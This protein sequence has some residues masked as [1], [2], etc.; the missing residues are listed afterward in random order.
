MNDYMKITLPEQGIIKKQKIDLQDGVTIL[1]GL[2]NCGKTSALRLLDQSLDRQSM[3]MIF[4]QDSVQ[5]ACRLSL[6]IP[7]NRVVVSTR[8]TEIKAFEDIESIIAYKRGSYAEYDFHLKGIR[9]YLLKSPLIREF[10]QNAVDRIFHIR[11]SGFD[12]RYSDGIENII[13]IYVN[14]LWILTWDMELETIGEKE[15]QGRIKSAPAYILI[16]EIEMFLHVSVQSN[17]IEGLARDFPSCSFV[18][19]THSPLLLTRYRDSN[20]FHLE[21]GVLSPI[22]DD[23]YFKDLDVIYESYFQV[24]EFP[25]QVGEDIR[26]LGDVLLGEREPDK[27]IVE[28]IVSRMQAQYPNLYRKYN[29][30]ITK[31]KDR[32]GL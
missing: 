19:S 2:N 10:I 23:L 22:C 3:G 8:F 24:K 28:E 14:I 5:A 29:N 9:D 15:L 25:A 13:N 7:T 20:V 6:Y 16:D 32:A 12:V 31:A 30:L 4:G 18:L 1:Y 17:L 26:Y 21:N 11:L 27:R